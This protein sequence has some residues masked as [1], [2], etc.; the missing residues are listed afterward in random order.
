MQGL[1]RSG[2][3]IVFDV[4]YQDERF[5]GYYEPLAK[6]KKVEAIPYY[7]IVKQRREEFVAVYSTNHPDESIKFNTLNYGAP[8]E[9]RLEYEKILPEYCQE[10]I[11]YL[12]AQSSGI[13]L[14]KFTRMHHKI[15]ALQEIDPTAKLV[16]I[17]RDP[18]SIVTSYLFGKQQKNKHLFDTPDKFFH[19]VSDYTAWSYRDFSEILL[20]TDEYSDLNDCE[21]FMRILIVWKDT[22]KAAIEGAKKYFPDRW[23]LLRHHDLTHNP[24]ALLNRL[25]DYFEL[26]LSDTVKQWAIA[27]VRDRPDMFE[28][29]N[30]AW[31][32]A[33]ERLKLTEFLE[34]YKLLRS[35]SY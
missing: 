15:S 3:S 10:Y 8:R 13:P 27:N 20:Q 19:S 31:T 22:V 30:P 21:D 9:A 12:I 4:L 17:A 24:E 33:F 35:D 18:R 28:P 34:E 5:E 32:H 2:T 16:I 26:P 29:E 14:L 1:R 23:F 11:Q 6:A 7:A 25:Y